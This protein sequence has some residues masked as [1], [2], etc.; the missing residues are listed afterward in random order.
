VE[1]NEAVRDVICTLLDGNGMQVLSAADGNAAI[2]TVR[3]HAA[4]IDL[5]LT[6]VVMPGMKG[7]EVYQALAQDHPGIKVLYMSGYTEDIIFSEG[8]L[9]EG[10]HF[11]VNPF[12]LLAMIE[13]LD[14]IFNAG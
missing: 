3:R 8:V 12:R 14:D 13:K 9:Q 7:P 6:D 5:L 11:S 4:S 10:I 1:D 2:E